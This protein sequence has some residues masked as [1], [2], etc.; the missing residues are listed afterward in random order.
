MEEGNNSLQRRRT[1]R[2]KSIPFP[3]M[4]NGQLPRHSQ[5]RALAR[6][7]RQLRRRAPDQR[8]HARRVDD[9]PFLLPKLAHTQHRMLAPKPDPLDIDIMR[10]IPDL[11]WRVDGVGVIRVHDAGVVEH[12][13]DAAPGVKVRDGG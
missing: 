4:D 12:D 7:I 1:K 3:R 8:N 2:I 10:E 5:H 9:T 13:V 6:R 11:L